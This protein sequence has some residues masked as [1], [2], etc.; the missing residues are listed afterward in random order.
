M[1][2]LRILERKTV[3]KLYGHVVEGDCWG[4]TNR[5]IKNILQ[6]VDIVRYIKFLRLRWY[7][8]VERMHNQRMPKQIATA[9]MEEGKEEDHVKDGETKLK[10]I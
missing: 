2:A 5:E 6:R 4:I 10:N 1:N 3:R 9:T 7:G 8:H